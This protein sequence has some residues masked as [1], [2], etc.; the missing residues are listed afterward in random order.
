MKH[1]ATNQSAFNEEFNAAIGFDFVFGGTWVCGS[2]DEA[3]ELF[4]MG[5]EL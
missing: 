5:G 2:V 1:I 3:A 4:C